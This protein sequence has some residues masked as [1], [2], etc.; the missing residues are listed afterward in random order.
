MQWEKLFSAPA[1]LRARVKPGIT[2]SVIFEQKI[3]P[4]WVILILGTGKF[5]WHS[6]CLSY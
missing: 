4:M 3:W 2:I 6:N 1:G 5:R